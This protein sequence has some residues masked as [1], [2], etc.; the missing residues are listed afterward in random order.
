MLWWQADSVPAKLRL[1][2]V[3]LR[4][5]A[6]RTVLSELLP[7]AA[8]ATTPEVDDGGRMSELDWR[9][10]VAMIRRLQPARVVAVERSGSL[11]EVLDRNGLLTGDTDYTVVTDGASPAEAVAAAPSISVVTSPIRELPNDFFD[12][13]RP[14]DLLFIDLPHEGTGTSAYS[15]LVFEV[16][17][18]LAP[19]VVVHFSGIRFPFAYATGRRFWWSEPY[20]VRTILLASGGFRVV[21]FNSLLETE[22]GQQIATA[23]GN[24]GGPQGSASLYLERRQP[25]ES[26]EPS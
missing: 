19:G 6:Q 2:T 25:Q 20:L 15:R 7:K 17:P 4:L 24:G 23:L 9:L 18:R 16:M 10:L 26:G 13:L 5:E 14:G 22:A 12:G 8:T 21:L 3:D 1:G 11:V